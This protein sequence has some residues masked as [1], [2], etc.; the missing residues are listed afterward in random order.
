MEIFINKFLKYEFIFVVFF[1]SLIFLYLSFVAK[2]K[3]FKSFCLIVF[4]ISISVFVIELILSFNMGAVS[5][6]PAVKYSK[7]EDLKTAKIRHVNILNVNDK[8]FADINQPLDKTGKD[9]IF[10]VVLSVYSNGFR[11]TKGN[12]D[13]DEAYVFLGCSNT[14]GHGVNDDETLPYYFSQFYNFSKNVINCGQGG[15][16]I[17]T[18]I[19]IL[20]SDVLDSFITKDTKIKYFIYS[21][22]D[23]HIGRNFKIGS[24]EFANDNFISENGEL[25]RVPQPFGI[26]KIVFAKS[27]IFNKV[28][29]NMIEKHNDM[30]YQNYMFES[31]NK[32][33]GIVERKYNSKLI[34]IIWPEVNKEFTDRLKKTKLDLILLPDLLNDKEYIISNDGHPNAKANKKISDILNAHINI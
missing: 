5:A 11:Y 14:F 32:L 24:Y 18:A 15:R 16:G 13:S 30:Y 25:K 34:V 2:K 26:V 20:Q 1:I 27:F 19:N 9:I 29:L 7:L 12:I 23:F 21:M 4:G 28:F 10:D 33:R 17:N 3:I 8:I 31:F 6:M 22:L